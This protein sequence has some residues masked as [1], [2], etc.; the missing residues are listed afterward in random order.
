MWTIY[1]DIEAERKQKT[2][3]QNKTEVFIDD[4]VLIAKTVS[5][6]GRESTNVNQLDIEHEPRI[7][8]NFTKVLAPI[9]A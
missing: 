2:K 1:Y 4:H 6:A 7:W 5:H 8:G 3:K 9:P